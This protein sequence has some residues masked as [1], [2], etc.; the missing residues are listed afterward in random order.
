MR[1]QLPDW[2][3]A[4]MRYTQETEPP[5]LYRKWVGISCIA[6]ALRRKV[7]LPWDIDGKLYPNLYVVLVGPPGKCRKGTAMSSGMSLAKELGIKLAPNSLTRE[8]LI[9]E[10]ADSSDI[11][12]TKDKKYITHASLTILSTELTVFLGYDNKQM[13]MDLT[14]WYDCLDNWEYRTKTQGADE[15]AGV[16]VNLLGATTPQQVQSALPPDTFG[17]GLASRI[18]FVFEEDKAKKVPEP[19]NSP[20]LKDLRQVLLEDL[21]MISALD[22]PFKVTREYMDRWVDWYMRSD[23]TAPDMPPT[24]EGYLNRRQT[25]LRKLSM[26]CSVSRSNDMILTKEDWDRALGIL[27]ATEVKMPRTFAGVGTSKNSQLLVQLMDYISTKKKVSLSEIYQDFYAYFD[28]PRH[29]K[30]QMEMLANQR[31]VKAQQNGRDT[32]LIYQTD[33]KLHAMFGGATTTQP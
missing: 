4:Y 5:V 20:E 12:I 10:L 11:T 3:D 29:F 18:I 26:L 33:H 16:W 8:Q 21:S 7:W 13:I 22:G 27:E 17:G 6:A 25:H 24:F 23:E 15:I 31:F 1:R 9:R 32:Y 30:E 14:D 2:I 28:S 19:H